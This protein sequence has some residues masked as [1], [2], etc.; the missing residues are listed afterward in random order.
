GRV[1]GPDG[2]PNL[3]LEPRQRTAEVSLDVVVQRLQRRDVEHTQ[4]GARR[5]MQPVERVQERGERLAGARRRLDQDVAAARDRG[6]AAFLRRRRCSKRPLEP[7]ARH[8]R[9]DAQRVHP[10]RV[11][12]V[13]QWRLNTPIAPAV[14]SVNQRFPSEPMATLSGP[15]PE[16]IGNSLT[17]PAGVMRAIWF[18]WFSANQRLPSGPETIPTGQAPVVGVVNW[19]I[20]PA[21]VMRPILL[22]FCSANQRFPSGPRVITA[23]PDDAVG[24]ENSVTT[25]AG[26]IR[27]ILLAFNSVNQRFPS[28]P[29]VM[30]CG[31]ADDVFVRNSVTLPAVVIRPILLALDSQNQRLPSLPTAIEP[32]PAFAVSIGNSTIALV[33][34]S[35][36][37]I[38][39]APPS[40]N[41]R[42]PSGPVTMPLKAVDCDGIGKAVIAPPGT[43]ARP[44]VATLSSVNQMLPSGPDVKFAGSA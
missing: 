33:L 38:L 25:P 21:V 12:S 1:A 34:G 30:P 35:S 10:A 4:S 23:G 9:E 36:R 8:R 29:A 43:V 6:P 11:L 7:G 19:V 18:A 40:T 14:C 28:G 44:I 17:T 2:D 41:H 15:I 37:P 32:P 3:R 16:P 5:R 24:T 13:G 22:A 42:L 26:V 20:R 31:N 39:A 27:P